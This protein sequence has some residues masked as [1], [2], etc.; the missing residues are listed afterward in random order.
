MERGLGC[1]Q[2]WGYP[3]SLIF[4]CIGYNTS[5]PYRI[6]E[7]GFHH[8][9]NRGFEKQFPV[10]PA[11]DD[12]PRGGILDNII[13]QISPLRILFFN[14]FNFPLSLPC[15][16]IGF[17]CKCFCK[18]LVIFKIHKSMNMILLCKSFIQF[19]LMFITT[20]KNISCYTDIEDSMW[21]RS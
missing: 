8:I 4:I 3:Q 13:I 21:L 9:Y 2:P 1:L 15:F 18:S 6:L 19:I 14:E 5:M 12:S 7:R 16:E 17:S 20:T 10:I 11:K